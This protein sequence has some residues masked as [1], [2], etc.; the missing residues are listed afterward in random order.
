M[1]LTYLDND[2][3]Y[4][5]E[6]CDQEFHSR[7]LA[8]ISLIAVYGAHDRQRWQTFPYLCTSAGRV[9]RIS[10]VITQSQFILCHFFV[11][12]NNIKKKNTKLTRSSL[13]WPKT[14]SSTRQWWRWLCIV[15]QMSEMRKL[16]DYI[17]LFN[18]M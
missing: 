16:R 8:A 11:F 18:Y 12:F 2:F 14:D 3:T 9:I 15:V 4:V 13:R 7:K 1:L 5:I 6:N 17:I 10:P